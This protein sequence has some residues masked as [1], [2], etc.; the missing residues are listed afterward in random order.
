MLHQRL[1]SV[2]SILVF[3]L[4]VSA[5]D[6]ESGPTKGEKVPA[7]KGFDATGSFKDKDVD[8]T[9]ERKDKPTVYVLIQA[10]KWTRPMARFLKKLDETLK[11][12]V[13]DAYLVAV[14]LTDDTSKT[15]EY[16]PVAQQSLNFEATA[17]TCFTGEKAGPKG[18]NVNDMA[19]ITVAVVNKQKVAATLG[20]ASINETEVRKVMAELKKAA[21]K[22][23]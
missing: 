13:E 20:Y 22:E 17:L 19:H 18:W 11:K 9:A 12:D 14:W 5:Q 2:S 23:K 6:I 8:Y 3:S 15:K 7:L 21:G 16:L 10:D 1:L 4:T